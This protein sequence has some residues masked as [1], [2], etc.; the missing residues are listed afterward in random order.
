MLI[1]LSPGAAVLVSCV[2][3]AAI[4][5]TT[6]LVAHRLPTRRLDH[7]SWL[8]RPR[9]VERGGRLYERL[10]IRRWKDRLPEQGALFRGG[11]SKRGLRDRSAD[12]LE[13]FVVETRRAEVVHW[14][15]AAAGPVFWVWCPPGLGAVMVVFGVT[16]HLPFV[17]IQRYNRFR[18]QRVLARRSG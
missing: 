18:L 13:R 12:H 11:F 1:R 9:A 17:C 2:A 5:L 6:G 15:N 7:D 3:W 16:V 8:T 14:A 4:G 10:G